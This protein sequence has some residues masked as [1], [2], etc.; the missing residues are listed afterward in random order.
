VS[1]G[2]RKG[3]A[4]PTPRQESPHEQAGQNNVTTTNHPKNGTGK[5]DTMKAEAW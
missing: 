3:T 2:K 5:T 1:D 4:L